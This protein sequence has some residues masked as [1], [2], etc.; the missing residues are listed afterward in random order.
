MTEIRILLTGNPNVGKTTLFNSLC[1]VYQ[2]TGNY[3]GV[4]VEI[5]EG[6]RKSDGQ[7][8]RIS[9]LPGTYS[10]SAFTPDEQVAR[11]ALLTS[12]P[13]VIVQIIDATNIERNLFLTTQLVEI[14]LPVIIAL[15]MVD[16]AEQ[17]GIAIDAACFSKSIGLPVVKVVASQGKG[18]E[19]L[20]QTIIHI[21]QQKEQQNPAQ[22]Q[23]SSTITQRR[24][25][26]SSFLNHHTQHLSGLT[27]EYTA[28][29]LLEGDQ[30]LSDKLHHEGLTIPVIDTLEPAAIDG[31][32][33][34]IMLARYATAEQIT[35]CS[36]SCSMARIMP[37]DLL[38]HVL[39]HRFFGIP[40]F[41][42]FMWFA[43]QLTFSASAPVASVLE[44]I[45][46][47]INEFVGNLG[48]GETVTSFISDG[49][50]GGV[51]TVLSFVPSIFILFLLLSLL[52]D[53]G[54][55]ARAAFV[56]DRLM[57]SIGLHGRSF[58]PLLI[59]FGCNV[60]AIMATRTL[61]SR[62]DRFITII[63]IPFMSCS[64]RLPV[65]VL[66]TG[67]FFGAHAGTVIFFLYILGILAAIGT[68]LLFRRLIFHDDPSPFIME[69]PPYRS[70]T[71]KAAALHMWQR[72]K[73]Y[74]QRAGIVI[75]G[76]VLVVWVLASLPFGVEYGSADS[77]AGVLGHLAEPIF[78]PLGFTWQL[79]V[80]LIFGFIAKEVVVG[81]LGT[82]YGGED[83]L[84]G[85]LAAD[86]SLGPVVALA[87]MVFVLLYL[88]C[89]AT[90]GVIKQEM[91]SWK[92]TGIALGWGILVAFILAWVTRIVGS[93][94]IGA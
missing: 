30:K 3:P 23:Y 87:Y 55:L 44:I 51:G 39:T 17:T 48:L 16:L 43:F 82:L 65:Y 46:G 8:F 70:P 40:I 21:S 53:S 61:Q 69:L 90:L 26:I 62:A 28:I 76:G 64:A 73:E 29:R 18:I 25:E 58:I 24:E 49:I 80:A 42:S 67:V 6:I 13:D 33:Q 12:H 19:D 93:L 57:H 50:I 32:I 22:A 34:E 11:D 59:G 10:L 79:V 71:L 54:Y 81:S 5:K 27:P 9:D 37:T 84:A 2:H 4:T 75:F 35:G 86:P 89:V 91:G 45:F 36:V 1:G 72:G 20:V 66:L 15:N 74:L 85:S 92:W 47:S 94:I 77:L 38:D 7:I 68:A 14:G 83:S 88:P 52:E 56:M 60:P 78:A 63:S 41:L 31:F